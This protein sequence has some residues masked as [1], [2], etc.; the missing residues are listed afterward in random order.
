MQTDHLIKE[1]SL[2][3]KDP[4]LHLHNPSLA[5]GTSGILLL[6]ATLQK[7]GWQVDDLVHLLVCKI[8]DNIETNGISDLSLFGGLSG[9]CFAL[10][11]ASQN[12][13]RYQPMLKTLQNYLL[14]KLQTHY[15]DP[16]AD[17]LKQ[18]LP[19][20]SGL[21]DVIQ[22]LAGIGRYLLQY[23]DTPRFYNFAEKIAKLLVDFT[24]SK[25]INGYFV[26]RWHLAST[27]TLNIRH[28]VDS[29]GNFNLGLAHGIPGVLSFLVSAT[30]RG[31]TVTGQ[32][33]AM[34]RIINWIQKNSV[35][36]NTSVR[37]PYSIG[38]NEEIHSI[39]PTKACKDAWCYGTPGIARTLFLASKVLSDEPLQVYARNAFYAIFTRSRQ[40]W[41]LPGPMLCHGIAGLLMLTA[42][43]RQENEC[44][45]L[46]SSVGLLQKMLIESYSLRAPYGFQDVEYT[47]T[48]S[49]KEVDKI[50]FLEGT[51]GVLLCLL[52][53]AD[54]QPEWLLPLLIYA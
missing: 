37:W 49:A 14:E 31:V 21:Y 42:A 30:T 39:K 46:Q 25:Q 52:T 36:A 33:E 41:Q 40:D 3:L 20:P 15:L 5:T 7:N 4:S 35:T 34:R 18:N 27:D 24:E 2:K 51:A 17:C 29:G 45:D 19:V 32:K 8:K 53:T 48:G 9:I 22:G 47:E 10:T 54:Q 1:I 43:M 50:G 23:P 28:Q 12:G 16:F 44:E 26:P 6:F 38:W 11:Q 13:M